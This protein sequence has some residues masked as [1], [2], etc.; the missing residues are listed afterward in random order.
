MSKVEKAAEG[1]NAVGGFC[2]IKAKKAHKKQIST[3]H[4]C[5]GSL[6]CVGRLSLAGLPITVGEN[7]VVQITVDSIVHH[8]RYHAPFF[9]FLYGIVYAPLLQNATAEIIH[10]CQ[11]TPQ[12]F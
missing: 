4:L 10:F 5:R 2:I 12:L 8:T 1:I 3:A 7:H 9:S 11:G 6:I